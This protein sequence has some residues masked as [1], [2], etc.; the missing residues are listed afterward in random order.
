[1]VCKNVISHHFC[2]CHSWSYCQKAER[3]QCLKRKLTL[4]NIGKYFWE[5][6]SVN[7]WE[8]LE[9]ILDLTKEEPEE[10]FR[11]QFNLDAD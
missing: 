7:T 11:R 5:L 2:F 9:K 8:G 10:R 3:A 4:S 6:I 1:M